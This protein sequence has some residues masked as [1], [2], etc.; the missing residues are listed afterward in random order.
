MKKTKENKKYW[1]ENYKTNKNA[2][3]VTYKGTEYLSKAQ[4]MAL[5]GITRKELDAYLKGEPVPEVAQEVEEE[6][7]VGATEE[8]LIS[9]D[10]QDE[11]LVNLDNIIL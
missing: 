9:I 5:E 3:P 2:K 11:D 1:F 8:E 10:E 6:T 4:C 7:T